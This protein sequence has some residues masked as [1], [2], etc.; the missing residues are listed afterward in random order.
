MVLRPSLVAFALVRCYRAY[1]WLH[2]VVIYTQLRYRKMSDAMD[3]VNN[4][5]HYKLG[6][7]RDAIVMV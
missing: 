5:L 7:E 4:T 1:A 2:V 3:V 6:N